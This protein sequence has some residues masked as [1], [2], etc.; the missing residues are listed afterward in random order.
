MKSW[1]EMLGTIARVGDFPGFLEEKNVNP[2][3]PVAV[4]DEHGNELD[5]EFVGFA[6]SSDGKFLVLVKTGG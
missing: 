2:D 1:K 4:G 6:L 3:Y 5:L